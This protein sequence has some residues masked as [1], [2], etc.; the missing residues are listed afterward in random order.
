MSLNDL[1]LIDEIRSGS[2]AAFDQL[3]RRHEK[4]VYRVAFSY[5][6]DRES[7]LDIS[8]NVFIK[9]HR[10]LEAFHG[11]S[12][13]RTWLARVAQNESLTWLRGQKRH[14]GQAEITAL[15]TPACQPTQEATL[16]RAERSRD[17]IEEVHRLNPKQSR[18]VLLRYYEKMSVREI[19][20][21]LECSE[22]QVKSILFRSLQVLR[23]RLP[24]KGRWNRELEA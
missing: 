8:Q 6:S 22:G 23:T 24:R 14:G 10:K 5:T 16:L 15:N 1:E 4:F 12:T 19:G 7:A 17:L 3:I 9:V 21:V 11:N 20:D 18:A 13:F 2:R